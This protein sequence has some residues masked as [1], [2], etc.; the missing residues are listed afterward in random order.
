MV[1]LSSLGIYK[2]SFTM[3]LNDYYKQCIENVKGELDY[4]C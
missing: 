4:E 3:T 2:T 1:S